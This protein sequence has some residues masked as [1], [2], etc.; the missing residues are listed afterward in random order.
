MKRIAALLLLITPLLAAEPREPASSPASL[1]THEWGTF[2][3]IADENGRPVRWAPLTGA[4]DLP[5]FVANLGNPD[6]KW[7]MFGTV[8]MET[9]VLYFYAPQPIT[10]S[11]GVRFPEGWITEWYPNTSKVVPPYPIPNVPF[12]NGEIR[13][14]SVE[15]LPGQTPKLRTSKGASH[16]FA[17]RETDAAPLR[18]GSDWEKLIFYRGV[19][20][21]SVPLRPI[22]TTEGRLRVHSESIDKIPLMILFENRAGKI[23]YRLV[24]GDADVELPELTAKLDDLRSEL[25]GHLVEFGLYR[26]EA[27][28][29]V[30]TWRDSWFEEGMRLFYIVPRNMVD[31][32]LPLDI[33][34]A[35]A[36]VA[37]VFVGRIELLSPAMRETIQSA[38]AAGDLKKLDSLGRFL[39]PFVTQMERTNPGQGRPAAI[40][41]IFNRPVTAASCV[42]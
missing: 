3:S 18:V 6:F 16:Y 35:P 32:V 2:T 28:A 41:T 36:F 5:C 4:S 1:V 7:R 24:R 26:K 8:R 34:P 19:G 23:G 40:Q 22:F 29:M 10:L 30:E 11:V 15:V 37:R 27:L 38:A 13:W 12:K 39:G 42:Q 20:Q 21:F 33:K 31:A 17:A 25:A 14:D 9:P